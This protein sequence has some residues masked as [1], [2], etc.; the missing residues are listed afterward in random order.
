MRKGVWK[1]EKFMMYLKA[2][3]NLNY[4]YSSISYSLVNT[5]YLGYRNQ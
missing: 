2:E 1:N 5:L 4:I 3:I